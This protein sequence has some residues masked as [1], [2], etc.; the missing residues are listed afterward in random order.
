[1]NSNFT[2]QYSDNQIY[3]D[4]QIWGEVDGGNLAIDIT[5]FEWQNP[6]LN[7]ILTKIYYNNKNLN[8]NICKSVNGHPY[9]Q[10]FLAVFDNKNDQGGPWA[11]ATEIDEVYATDKSYFEITKIDGTTKKASGN[12]E[13]KLFREAQTDT[14]S[15]TESKTIKGTFTNLCYITQ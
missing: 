2:S 12:F 6:T 4:F 9:C 10:E 5:N 7:T 15:Y 8:S 14:S 1:M 11:S 3:Y 13:I